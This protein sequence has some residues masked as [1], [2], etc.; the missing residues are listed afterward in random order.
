MTLC[1]DAGIMNRARARVPYRKKRRKRLEIWES[2]RENCRWCDRT[3]VGSDPLIAWT[4]DGPRTHGHRAALN[5]PTPH[6]PFTGVT[7]RL[8][9]SPRMSYDADVVGFP[10]HKLRQIVPPERISC[11]LFG[12]LRCYFAVLECPRRR[13]KGPG[14]TAQLTGVVI[15][16][17]VVQWKTNGGDRCRVAVSCRNKLWLWQALYVQGRTH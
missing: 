3:E 11:R 2:L 14:D 16:P 17:S 4:E 9:S 12:T 6:R 5:N 10:Q 1:V 7:A 15:D 13:W 8:H